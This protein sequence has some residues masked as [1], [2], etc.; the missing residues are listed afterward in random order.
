MDH[1]ES[2]QDEHDPEQEQLLAAEGLS[3]LEDALSYHDENEPSLLE[4]GEIPR[5]FDGLRLGELIGTGGMGEVYVA[6]Q[7]GLEREVAVKIRVAHSCDAPFADRLI[8][9]EART[10]AELDHS[11]IARVHST[12][13]VKGRRY[14]VMERVEGCS[15]ATFME[16]PVSIEDAL[17]LL[18]GMARALAFAH[19][20]GVPHRDLKPSNVLIADGPTEAS[21]SQRVRLIDFGLAG[22]IF[23]IEGAAGMG[24]RHYM[25]PEQRAGTV[26]GPEADVYAMRQT[27]GQ[28]IDDDWLQIP[29]PIRRLLRQMGSTAPEARPTAEQVAR[30][31]AKLQTRGTKFAT[32]RSAGILLALVVAGMLGWQAYSQQPLEFQEANANQAAQS[33]SVKTRRQEFQEQHRR[34]MDL[35]ATLRSADSTELPIS[36]DDLAYLLKKLPRVLPNLYEQVARELPRYGVEVP[37]SRHPDAS[38]SRR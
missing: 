5:E 7:E 12:G 10:L 31:I 38:T 3:I 33:P 18:L 14:L 37:A 35:L 21:L 34:F 27:F 28:L 24:T 36:E 1:D 16:Q 4:R 19:A 32:M 20:S 2:A 22:R 29:G 26:A 30:E 15:L 17:E 11:G 6:T 13:E 25:A 9:N 23:D 8:A